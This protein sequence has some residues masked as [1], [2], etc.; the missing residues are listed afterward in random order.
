MTNSPTSKLIAE[1]LALAEK[2]TPGPWLAHYEPGS[3]S[4]GH[5]LITQGIPPISG[6]F[7]KLTDEQ[8]ASWR[9]IAHSRTAAPKLAEMLQVACEALEKYTLVAAPHLKEPTTQYS[10]AA[11]ALDQIDRIAARQAAGKAE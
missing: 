2:A 3:I 7:T 8:I 6:K 1:T 4:G 9:F 11:M 5:A 10:D